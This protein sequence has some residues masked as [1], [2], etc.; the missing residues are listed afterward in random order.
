ML[1]ARCLA[2][3]TTPSPTKFPLGH[4]ALQID[5][6]LLPCFLKDAASPS[7]NL[8]P[9]PRP[10][11]GPHSGRG[12]APEG[13]V[14]P[15]LSLS[16]SPPGSHSGPNTASLV[17]G[18]APPVARQAEPGLGCQRWR[19]ACLSRRELFPRPE[20]PRPVS[21]TPPVAPCRLPRRAPSGLTAAP[22]P[23][24]CTEHGSRPVSRCLVAN[25]S[26]QHPRRDSPSRG[27]MP[28]D[29]ASGSPPQRHSPRYP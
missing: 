27:P 28:P 1:D 9:P 2:A 21:P 3:N 14:S 8:F 12:K 4:R 7:H 16:P 24:G 23:A 17:S 22:A 20:D 25:P 11:I 6:D 13:R 19:L 10:L 18:A 29:R 26:R 5:R 15:F